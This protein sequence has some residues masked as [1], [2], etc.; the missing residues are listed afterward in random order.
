MTNPLILALPSKGRLREQTFDFLASCGLPVQA[1]GNDREYTGKLRGVPDVLIQFL[2]PDEIPHRLESGE[3]HLGITGQDL[4]REHTGAADRNAHLLIDGLG[5]G[6]ANLVVAVP[7]SWIDVV[8]IADLEEIALGLR[9]RRNRSL[10]VATK[11]TRLTREFFEQHG[12]SDYRI[13]ESLGSTEVTP[14][15]GTADIIVDLTSTG[16]TLAQNHL[17]MLSDGTIIA[18]Q[19]CLLASFAAP[20]PESAQQTLRHMLD[21]MEAR[22]RAQQRMILHFGAYPAMIEQLRALPGLSALCLE[23]LTVEKPPVE[24]GTETGYT[25]HCRSDEFYAL[26]RA[27]RELGC[28]EISAR[29]V[30]YMFMETVEGFQRFCYLLDKYGR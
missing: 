5:F 30:D 2:R 20:W 3:V 8:S 25:G 19:A 13:V 22:L 14:A 29:R 10:R 26:V 16:A 15:A 28:R 11:F 7:R 24:V 17:K 23:T 9:Q 6:H 21:V 27:L 4:F 1:G 12:I 18:S